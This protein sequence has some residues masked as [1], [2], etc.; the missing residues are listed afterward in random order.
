MAAS[1]N[2]ALC[3]ACANSTNVKNRRLLG[4]QES[5]LVTNIWKEMVLNVSQKEGRG[6]NLVTIDS[7]KEA[8]VCKK[9]FY[10]YTTY[11]NKK[12]VSDY[13]LIAIITITQ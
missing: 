8:Y 1:S 3:L 10:A 4:T 6:V 9:C 12:E 13:D 2:A 5:E 7:R 11:A